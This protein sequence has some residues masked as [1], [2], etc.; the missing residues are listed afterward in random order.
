MYLVQWN[1]GTLGAYEHASSTRRDR[2]TVFRAIKI[3]EPLGKLTKFR[4]N[5]N[6]AGRTGLRRG[7]WKV[8]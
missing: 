7:A 5:W 3:I 8:C 2:V 6:D 1:F 4:D